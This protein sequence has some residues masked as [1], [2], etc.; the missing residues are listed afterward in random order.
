MAKN[1]APW[2][3]ELTPQWRRMASRTMRDLRAELDKI[4]PHKRDPADPN[5]PNHSGLF[6]EDSRAF[7]SRQNKES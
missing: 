4:P 6:G 5:H 2:P 1:Y 7:M 3:A